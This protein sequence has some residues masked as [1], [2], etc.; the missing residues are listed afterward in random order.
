M[1]LSSVCYNPKIFAP[2][3]NSLLSVNQWQMLQLY[4]FDAI[5]LP[6]TSEKMPDPDVLAIYIKLHNEA[7]AFNNNVLPKVQ[8]LGNQLYNYGQT[9]S[10]TLNTVVQLM[11]DPNPNK[12]AV[13]Q[14]LSNLQ[15]MAINY[16]DSSNEIYEN[17]YL[18]I[19]NIQE[20][21]LGLNTL[22]KQENNNIEAD[23][24]RI[25][26][27]QGEYNSKYADMQQAQAQIVSDN[28]TI[29][30]AKYYIWIPFVGTTVGVGE[31]IAEQED[32]KHQLDRIN[33]NSQ[34]LQGIQKEL[35]DVNTIIAHLTYANQYNQHLVEKMNNVMPRLQLIE[36][37]WKT[38]ASE[39]GDVVEN[40]KLAAASELKNNPCLSSV[41]LATAAN[42]W[43]DAAKDADS[44]RSRFYIQAQAA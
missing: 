44:F 21:A 40:V 4:L 30:N 42:E 35:Q 7:V 22:L 36:G 6:L 37:A 25:Q 20:A 34:A 39:I 3:N 17:I 14:Q 9:A 5:N 10:Q 15:A 18:Y 1:G 13:L 28:N 27:L 29:D 16:Q 41:E 11:D 19:S 2:E 43:L 38:V 8:I 31:I 26:R 33:A 32:I 12:D 24:L 23:N